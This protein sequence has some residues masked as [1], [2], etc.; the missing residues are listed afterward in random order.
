MKKNKLFG[1]EEM[2]TIQL[3]TIR[4]YEPNQEAL[5]HYK[6]MFD[7]YTV[8]ELKA[9]VD[10][11]FPL[12]KHKK[13][14]VLS[15]DETI[16][17]KSDIEHVLTKKGSMCKTDLAILLAYFMADRRNMEHYI[18]TLSDTDIFLWKQVI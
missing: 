5:E 4:L 6:R 8:P 2:R 12:L 9:W 18:H 15:K 14:E 10:N 17:H 1:E 11:L 16:V 13:I 3:E 7:R